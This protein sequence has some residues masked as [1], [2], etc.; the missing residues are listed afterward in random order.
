[1]Q[2]IIKKVINDKNV[3]DIPLIYIMRVITSFTNAQ[4]EV[5]DERIREKS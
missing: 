3:Q 1:M 4:M 2:E 5:E